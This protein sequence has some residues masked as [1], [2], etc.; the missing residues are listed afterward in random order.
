MTARGAARRAFAR[1]PFHLAAQL[2]FGSTP[3]A[4]SAAL[5]VSP[6]GLAVAPSDSASPLRPYTTTTRLDV[7]RDVLDA[8]APCCADQRDLDQYYYGR[9]YDDDDYGDDAPP[10]VY[11]IARRADERSTIEVEIVGTFARPWNEDL[12]SPDDAE[13]AARARDVREALLFDQVCA[14]P[15]DDAPRA[16]L[17]DW[18]LERGDPLGEYVTLALASGSERAERLRAVEEALGDAWLGPL[19]AVAP[20]EGRRF[21]RGFVQ[22]LAVYGDWRGFEAL[23]NAWQWGSVETL[24]FLPG[25][26][27]AVSRTMRALRDVGPLD[28]AGVQSLA[29]HGAGLPIEGLHLVDLSSRVMRELSAIE[30]PRLRRVALGRGR[31]LARAPV[32]GDVEGLVPWSAWAHVEEI[33]I[34]LGAYAGETVRAWIDAAAAVVDG[35][36]LVF[37]DVAPDGALAGAR[38]RVA[39]GKAT[40]DV[41]SP[42]GALELADVGAWLAALPASTTVDVV[43][44][45][46]FAAKPSDVEALS[47]AAH[48][49]IAVRSA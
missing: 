6:G 40:L 31:R 33:E 14:A 23:A 47:D 16:V 30:L 44:T 26:T 49:A 32:P 38:L 19:A 18:L 13:L 45:R 29:Q 35:R 11:A 43:P 39:A 36:A 17:A 37:R 22:E 34:E 27:C 20:P 10:S 3:A 25:S 21:A 9:G 5:L 42:D 24:R 12:P 48:R 2:T 28:L 1:G 7:D 15:E 41:T 8:F 46:W 4:R